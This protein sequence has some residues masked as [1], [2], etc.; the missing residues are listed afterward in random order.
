MDAF[1]AALDWL[2]DPA[3]WRGDSG[4]P[5]LLLQHVLLTVTSLVVAVLVAL[6][7][8]L[9][10]GH[11][12]KG[13]ALAINISN[14][15]RAVPTFAVLILLAVGFVG[16]GVFGPFGRTGLAT[17]IALVVFALPPIV[18]NAYVGMREVDRDTV[19]AARGMG[20]RGGQLFRRVELPLAVPLILTGLRLAVVQ[21]W[22]T[23]TLAALVDGPGLGNIIVEG[24]GLQDPAQVLAGAFI[25]AGLALLLEVALAGFARMVDPLR[26]AR[27]QALVQAQVVKN[28]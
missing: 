10:L 25:V 5:T 24:F 14:I 3:H 28:P 1:G 16:S 2:A 22:A 9:W 17:L 12:G 15:G 23:A 4:I 11:L 26:P 13:G 21:V 19:E 18:T 27:R 6:P 20:M 8:A 7:V